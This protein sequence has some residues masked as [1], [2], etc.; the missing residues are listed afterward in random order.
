MSK[1]FSKQ[2]AQKYV[3]VHRPHDDPHFYDEGASKHI[4]VP[5]DD[6]NAKKQSGVPATVKV[7]P[8]GENKHVGEAAL[9]G[10]EFDDSKYDYT[11]HL[12]PMGVN[13]DSVF[14]PAKAE[15]A[16]GKKKNID[17]LF[18]EPEYKETDGVKPKSV[19]VRGVADP[20]YLKHQQDV[21]EDI[22]GFRPNMDPALR[23][24]LEALEDDAY[25]VND[26]IV[27]ASKKPADAEE[28]E[29]EDDVF[30]EL[31]QGGEV[32]DEDEVDEWD[33]DNFEDYED[34]TYLKEMEQFDNLENLDD[35]QNIDYQADV[36]RFQM[37][38]KGDMDLQS[39]NE[40][41]DEEEEEENDMLGELPTIKTNQKSKKK[42]RR[43][44]GAMSDI[45]GF[46]MSSSAIARTETM[47]VLDDHYDQ[48]ITGYENYEEEQEEEE[49][50]YKPFNMENERSDFESMLDDFLDNYE[51]EK[52][53]R[54]L[55]KKNP[56][57]QRM[58]DAADEVS[59]G[60]LSMKRNRE[61][62]KQVDN[63]TNSL[64]SLKF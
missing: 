62:Q 27:V 60:K 7:E 56:E 16:G 22:T 5:V 55:V 4:L 35:L 50:N 31:L 3:V 58:K 6:P 33:I 11:Q 19:F 21:S 42:Q 59:K 13:A 26:D 30:A 44:K 57:V 37:Q 38:S 54:K 49:D 48:I 12:R 17:D 15:T 47:T 1:R 23:E 18:V 25:V 14:I 10:I 39:E 29:D 9:Y 53:G 40:F 64:S 41:N 45:S 51:L 8:K 32:A 28:E 52:G 61:R 20:E 46:S 63:L 2:N 34:E 43:K 36:R 24:V